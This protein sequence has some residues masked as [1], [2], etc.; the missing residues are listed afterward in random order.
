MK[1]LH[2]GYTLFVNNTHFGIEDL[3]GFGSADPKVEGLS[4]EEHI[5]Y[6]KWVLDT[7][8]EAESLC[9]KHLPNNPVTD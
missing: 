3:T 8:F 6:L 5:T 1:Q 7:Y 9:Y 2:K 4:D